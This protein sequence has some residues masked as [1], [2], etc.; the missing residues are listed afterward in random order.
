MGRLPSE[1]KV[2]IEAVFQFF[3]R[4][5][6][7]RM[8][9]FYR[10]FKVTPQTE[11]LDLG[12]REFNWMLMPFHPHV[13][14]VNRSLEGKRGGEIQWILADVRDL[15]F[16]D[17]AFEIVYSNSVIE[18]LGTIAD[19]RR[20]AAECRRVGRSYY[21]QTPNR[22][23]PIEPH[24]LTPFI[25][26]LPEKLQARLLR[27]FTIWGWITRPNAAGRAHFLNTTRMLTRAEFQALF[28][29]AE[30]WTE[31][32]LWLTKSFAAVKIENE[33]E[34]TR[35]NAR[36]GTRTPKDFSTRS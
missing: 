5:R 27:N 4:F 25:H 19:Q 16:P 2:D 6:K 32:F 12:G 9:I 28:P 22:H 15:P 3:K 23:F 30:I 7:R 36:E 13:T 17:K 18:H 11:V 10:R 24:L 34:Q 26:W 1:T 14:I 33:K 21:I 8:Q 35:P 29:E 31:Y 20:F